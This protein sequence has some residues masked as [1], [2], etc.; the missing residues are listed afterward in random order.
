MSRS[1]QVAAVFSEVAE[2]YDAV[3]IPWFTP[4]AARLVEQ[5]DPQPGER[6]LDVGTGRGA[7]LLP[8][9]E[10]VGAGGA[11][12]GIDIAE[13][14]VAL[15]ARDVRHLPHV[16]VRVADASDPGLPEASYD[17]V[18]ASL[19]AFFL[20]EP[21]EALR[22]W[23]ALLVPGG[24]LGISTFDRQDPRWE[25]LDALFRPYLPQQMLDARTSGRSGPFGSDAGVEDLLRGAGLA[26]V[27]TSHAVVGVELGSVE[28]WERFTRSHG[29][30]A[31]WRQVPADE[32]D[33]LREQASALLA[34]WG[35]P[36]TL[37]QDVRY[38]LGRRD[39][40]GGPPG[41]G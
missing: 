9:A 11:V 5:L 4:I 40:A 30:R 36:V 6:V 25:E 2:V 15:T 7:A 14:M 24:R 8:L 13:P 21:Q 22:T 31:M 19:V 1:E 12:L 41:T 37:T 34:T 33:R 26:D 18:C 28:Q 29:Q 27:V 39:R 3:G 23:A 35:L 38:T 16:E 32:Q 10:A 20:P 17:V